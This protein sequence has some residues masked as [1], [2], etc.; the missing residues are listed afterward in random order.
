MNAV[1]ETLTA[2]IYLVTVDQISQE[3]TTASAADLA[4]HLQALSPH[5]RAGQLARMLWQDDR[6]QITVGSLSVVAIGRVVRQV[7][8]SPLPRRR[9]SRS[10]AD[11]PGLKPK[12]TPAEPD[13]DPLALFDPLAQE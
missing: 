8:G 5:V 3:V 7:W 13:D 12:I 4:A 2:R 6:A 11:K 1:R 10:V 9:P